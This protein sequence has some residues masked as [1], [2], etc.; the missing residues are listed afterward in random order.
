MRGGGKTAGPRLQTG[1]VFMTLTSVHSGLSGS[2][3]RVVEGLC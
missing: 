1:C 3:S 2:V